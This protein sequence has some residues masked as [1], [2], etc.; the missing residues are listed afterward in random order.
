[1]SNV[2]ASVRAVTLPLNAADVRGLRAGDRVRLTGSVLAARDAAHQRMYDLLACGEPL[3][4]ELV[5]ET[6]YYVG[7]S[8]AP[9]GHIVGSAGPTS[10]YRMDT[11]TPL[12]LEHGLRGMIGKGRRSRE[13]V[14]AIQRHQAVYLGAIGGAGA[15]LAR[16]IRRQEPVAWPDLGAEAVVRLWL[17]DFPVVVLNDAHG[18]DLYDDAIGSGA[19]DE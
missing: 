15:L 17:E 6:I 11:F 13:V 4:F 5:G 16:K 14:Q 10:S 2:P 19:D 9:P 18:A 12:L 8:P 7:P 3:P 1:M